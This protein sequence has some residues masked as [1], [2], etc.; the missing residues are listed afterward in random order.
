MMDPFEDKP[1]SLGSPLGLPGAVGG[2]V[3]PGWGRA[4]NHDKQDHQSTWRLVI[5]HAW[6]PRSEDW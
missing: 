1:Q 4:V 3:T 2:Q 5:P 6:S